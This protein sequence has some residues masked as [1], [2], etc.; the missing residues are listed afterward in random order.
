[1]L[2]SLAAAGA[3]SEAQLSTGNDFESARE[4]VRRAKRALKAAEYRFDTECGPNNSLS[5]MTEIRIAERRLAAAVSVL[6]KMPRN[7][8]VLVP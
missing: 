3:L 6:D 4:A 8:S 5:L 2:R 7:G 1:M